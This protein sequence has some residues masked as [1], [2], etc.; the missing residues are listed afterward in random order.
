[1]PTVGLLT[2]HEGS[3]LS[4]KKVDAINSTS[5]CLDINGKSIENKYIL[6]AQKLF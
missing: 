6:G 5:H 4:R 1:M 3:Q 2:W